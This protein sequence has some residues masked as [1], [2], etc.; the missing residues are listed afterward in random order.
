[1]QAMKLVLVA[2]TVFAAV[3]SAQIPSPALPLRKQ[4]AAARAGVIHVASNATGLTVTGD[5]D[6]PSPR[7]PASATELSRAEHIDVWLTDTAAT[8]LPPVGWGH[9]FDYLFITRDADCSTA[10]ADTT[11]QSIRACIEWFHRETAARPLAAR[12]FVRRWSVTPTLGVE[13][14]A[15]PAYTSLPSNVAGALRLFAPT[16]S[17]SSRFT[18]SIGRS[19]YHFAITIPWDALPPLRTTDL[20]ALRLVVDVF[21]MTSDG[22][23]VRST[24]STSAVNAAAPVPLTTPRRY[25]APCNATFEEPLTQHGTASASLDASDSAVVYYRP[26]QSTVLR[27]A[28]VLDVPA[29]GYL[30]E[31][32]PSMSAFNTDAMNFW[33]LRV[34]ENETLCG[35]HLAYDRAGV[36]TRSAMVVDLPDSVGV[37]RIAP[38]DLLIRAGPRTYFSY[39]GSGQCGGCARVRLEMFHVDRA[40]GVLTS[41]FSY[42]GIAEPEVRDIDIE[43]S[44]D[45][46]EL[47]IFEG[48]LDVSGD[49]TIAKWHATTHCYAPATHKYEPC[50]ERDGVF[51]PRKRRIVPPNPDGARENTSV[52]MMTVGLTR[53]LL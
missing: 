1:M 18:T 43:L 8:R 49:T 2:L 14:F 20:S 50:R 35:P 23:L 22:T 25:V 32:D 26:G 46:R 17:V 13:T 45:W 21:S 44:A 42:H 10:L 15:R 29:A 27:S 24:T 7:W 9:Q 37:R 53:P 5:V 31:P 34:G 36:I 38:N 11:A 47:T 16:G 41:A 40:T 4:D 30:Y 33:S 3:V 48:K 51:P 39:Y 28:I 19:G 52:L 12:L 6:G